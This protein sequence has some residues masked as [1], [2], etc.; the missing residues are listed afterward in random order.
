MSENNNHDNFTKL[1][2]PPKRSIDMPGFDQLPASEKKEIVRDEI[3]N[4]LTKDRET[5][6]LSFTKKLA[7]STLGSIIGPTFL[8]AMNGNPALTGSMLGV[9]ASFGVL[10]VIDNILS[11]KEKETAIQNDIKALQSKSGYVFSKEQ[12]ANEVD[13]IK[14]E[15]KNNSSLSSTLKK[16]Q[17]STPKTSEPT[18]AI[19]SRYSGR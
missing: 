6:K 9:F 5:N 19:P 14:T 7:C 10:T 15:L 1:P 18:M 8:A 16:A 3:R 17:Q 11:K 13:V 2:E 12:M 4:I